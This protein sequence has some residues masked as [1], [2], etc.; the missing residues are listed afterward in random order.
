MHSKEWPNW[1]VCSLSRMSERALIPVTV[2][3]RELCIQIGAD[4]VYPKRT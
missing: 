2:H 1:Y 4:Q 3:D